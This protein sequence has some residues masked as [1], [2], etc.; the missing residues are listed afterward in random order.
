MAVRITDEMLAIVGSYDLNG[1]LKARRLLKAVGVTAELHRHEVA[2]IRENREKA[3]GLLAYAA[4]ME[5]AGPMPACT[6]R[7]VDGIVKD[8]HGCPLG[9][10]PGELMIDVSES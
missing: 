2:A 3:A 4:R 10:K 8:T 7:V 1:V 9:H 6:C 5:A